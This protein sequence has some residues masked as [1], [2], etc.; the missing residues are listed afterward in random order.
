MRL[1]E[2]DRG[3]TLANRLLIGFI[4]LVSGMRLPDAARV[5]FYHT[6]FF[7]TPMGAWTQAA[8]RGPSDWSVGE[9]EL[10]AAMVAKWNACDFCVSAHGAV[11]A[12]ILPRPAVDAALAD[13][14]AAPISE[15]LK[16]TLAFLQ[17]MTLRPMQLTV[18]DARAVLRSGVSRQ[19]LTDAIA[20]AAIFNIVTR[21]AD[22]LDF[23]MPQPDE[24]E[25]AANML[26]KRG[27]G[28]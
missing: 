26:L 24:F 3:D 28:S 17:T 22:A 10:M 14:R 8:M 2:I 7:G 6:N 15:G 19:A 13:F 5:A 1:T 16:E 11:A 23:A 27:Y 25:R 9:R 12:K 20:V 18:E 4:S 21:Y